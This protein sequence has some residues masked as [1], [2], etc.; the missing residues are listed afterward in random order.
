VSDSEPGP[1]CVKV[2][3]VIGVGECQVVIV[4]TLTLSAAASEVK[5]VHKSVSID[6]WAVDGG[7]VLV[8]G[9]VS[10]NVE[11]EREDHVVGSDR[12]QVR[13]DCCLDVPGACAGDRFILE[14]GE[15]CVEKD[16]LVSPPSCSLFDK[17]CVHVAGKVT[18]E[19]EV[20]I[21]PETPDACPPAPAP[22]NAGL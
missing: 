14:S 19:V 20:T 22:C 7:K 6:D 10:K 4:S 21:A 17:V 2:P 1:I 9:T 8:N 15:V 12:F 3:Q 13:F 18:R 16:E 11:Y 5:R